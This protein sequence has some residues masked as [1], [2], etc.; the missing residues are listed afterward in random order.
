MKEPIK[1]KQGELV[2]IY[3]ANL[4]ENDPINSIHIHGNFSMN[5]QLEH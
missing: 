1:V 4:V 3:I 2:R 5:T